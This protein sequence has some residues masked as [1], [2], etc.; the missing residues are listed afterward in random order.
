[1]TELYDFLEENPWIFK[2]IYSILTICIGVLLYSFSSR[3]YQNRLENRKSPF[4]VGKRSKTYVN[5]VKNINKYIFF[6]IVL[7]VILK[8]NGVNI[9]SLVAGVGVAGIIIA[10]AIQDALKDIIKGI[11]IISDNYY[12]VGDVITFDKFTGKVLS[13]GIKTTK[14]EDVFTKNVVSISNRVIEKVEV[15]SH[16]ININIPLP[17]ELKLKKAEEVIDYLVK[18]LEKL[19]KV[20]KVE[21]M[22]VQEIAPSS[23]N[24]RVRVYTQPFIKEQVRRESLTTIIEGLEEKKVKIPY[25]QID[26]H[27]K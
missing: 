15:I 19:E 24:Y 26:V 9:T 4:F 10:F 22:G 5:L 18:K 27:Q 25:N 6:L 16:L 1:M 23:I 12:Q 14:I 13:I 7:I 20:E 21:Y 2:V 17:Y 3:V 11:D 8:I